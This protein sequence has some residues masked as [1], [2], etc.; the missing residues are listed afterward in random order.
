MKLR[1]QKRGK[2][3]GRDKARCHAHDSYS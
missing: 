1:P 3:C 2:D